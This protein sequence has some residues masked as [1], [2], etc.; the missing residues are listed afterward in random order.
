MQDPN[1]QDVDLSAYGAQPVHGG[2]ATIAPAAPPATSP[3][4]SAANNQDVDLSAYGAKPANVASADAPVTKSPNGM[5]ANNMQAVADEQTPEGH[6]AAVAQREAQHPIV[7]GLGEAAGDVWDAVKSMANPLNS[8]LAGA[9]TQ[10]YEH[11]K[12]AVPLFQTYENA[13]ANGKTVMESLGE[14][15]AKAKQIHDAQD[16]VKQRVDEF[17][18]NPTVATTRAV[19]DAA[20]LAATMW[21]GE[22]LEAPA[23]SAEAQAAGAVTH[24]F[25]PATG[26]L[27]PVP[28]PGI[29]QQVLKGEKVAQPQAEAAVRSGVQA[30]TEAAGT[31]DESMANNIQNQPLMKGNETVIDEHLSTLKEREQAAYDKM[32][33]AAGFDVKAEKQQLANDQ[34]KLNQLGNTDADV[35]QKGNLIE[36]INDSQARIAD[37]EAAMKEAGVDPKAADAIHQQR[38]AGNDFKK[39]LVKNISPDGTVNVNGLLNASKNLRFAKYGDRLAQFLG[40]PEAADSFM[41]DLGKAQE[42]GAH[43][44][45]AQNIAKMVLKYAPHAIGTIGGIGA[46]AYALSK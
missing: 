39:A 25:D 23:A 12:E 26:E 37:A 28:K 3:T 27:S 19:A 8:G 43:A 13:R 35:T 5:P 14:A 7:T 21:T 15:N 38:M 32:D 11:I 41:A 22:P 10:A 2:A 29:I 18:K 17:K 20:A 31:A 36:S 34:Y 30:S 1:T 46:A 24:V 45:K 42:L 40:S 4:T 16:V 44:L 6:A 33:E 9:T